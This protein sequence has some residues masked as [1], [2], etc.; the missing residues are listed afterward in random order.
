MEDLA[1][2]ALFKIVLANAFFDLSA[3]AALR[4]F[5]GVDEEK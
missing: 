2:N 5:Y 4:E 1:H 3:T